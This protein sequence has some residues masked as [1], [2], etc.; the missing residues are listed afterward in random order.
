[1]IA[2]SVPKRESQASD[3]G[4]LVRYISNAHGKEER[5][6]VMTITNSPAQTPRDLAQAVLLTQLLNGRA[7]S[8]KT[9]HLLLSFPPGEQPSPEVLAQIEKRMCDALGFGE[10]QR[11]SAVHHDTDDLHVHVAINKIHPTKLTI[12][13]PKGDYRIMA[14]TCLKLEAEFGL[15]ATNHTS[16][17]SVGEGRADDMDRIAGLEPLRDYVRRLCPELAQAASWQAV[18][19]QLG[20]AGLTIKPQ[21]AG[22]VILDGK[23]KGVKPSTVSRDL[24]KG[25]IEKRLGPFAAAV[26]DA[27]AARQV[28]SP[29]P[30]ATQ[31]RPPRV[32]TKELYA[33]YKADQAVGNATRAAASAALTKS[34]RAQ[35]ATLKVQ[36]D[37]QR[38]LIR[39][40]PTGGPR[41]ALLSVHAA[42]HRASVD[43]V[44]VAS[45]QARAKLRASSVGWLEWLQH[46]ALAG[47][48]QALA[49]LRDRARGEPRPTSGLEAGEGRAPFRADSVTKTGV[50]IYRTPSATVRD[51]GVRL[52]VSRGVEDKGVLAALQIAKHRHDGV[53][54]VAGDASFQARVARLAALSDPTIRFADPVLATARGHRLPA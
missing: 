49:A 22:L 31:G 48:G 35:L 13:S 30:T 8:D 53:L 32:N 16:R 7:T 41:A 2:R 29:A 25:Q 15:V 38:Q 44:L 12:H 9:Y 17:K 36:A 21:G 26:G 14:Q 43:K 10:H 52:H 50:F 24:A 20:A 28:Y 47:D 23:G 34:T 37:L 54:R 18:H 3:Y 11:I 1:M 33:R 5:V 19:H 51:D 40:A 46:Q 6:G 42:A 39:F 27:T 4:A 45:K